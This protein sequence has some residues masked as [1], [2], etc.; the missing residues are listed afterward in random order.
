MIQLVA[1][2]LICFAVCFCRGGK[3]IHLPSNVLNEGIFSY[4]PVN[5]EL[6]DL[7][8]LNQRI[9]KTCFASKYQHSIIDQLLSILSLP[10]RAINPYQL[11]LISNLT[12]QIKLNPFYNLKL[13]QILDLINQSHSRIAVTITNAMYPSTIIF[14]IFTPKKNLQSIVRHYSINIDKPVHRS[15]FH[16]AYRER[17]TRVVFM[18]LGTNHQS[19]LF[20]MGRSFYLFLRAYLRLL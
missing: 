17:S 18:A 3:F 12:Q 1:T 8:T 16:V 10:T 11:Q 13:P 19:C 14:R 7:S 20:T 9:Y 2:T 15:L 6:F 5:Q 4:L